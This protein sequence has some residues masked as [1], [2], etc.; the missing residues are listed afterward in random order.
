[1][2]AWKKVSCSKKYNE[3][4]SKYFNSFDFINQ[5]S[6]NLRGNE[7]IVT[8][9]GTSFTCTMQTF[10][11]KNPNG[12][13]LFTSSG[14][15]SMGFGLP[16]IIGAFFADRK[17]TPICISGDGGLMFNLQE[18][19]TVKSYKIPIKLFILENKGYLTMKLM[20]KKNFNYI[21]GADPSSGVTF[22]SFKK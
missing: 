12:Q 6:L 9:M 7:T 22:P 2:L 11:I 8:D 19:Q 20:Q 4:N 16:G 3:K 5:L 21:T 10:K 15:A 18:L 17:K 1:M 14:L 13:R